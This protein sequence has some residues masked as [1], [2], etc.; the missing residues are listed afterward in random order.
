MAK[1]VVILQFAAANV[2]IAHGV[3]H[4]FANPQLFEA[5]DHDILANPQSVFAK[6]L[7]FVYLK[8]SNT[9][10]YDS[11][12][13][14]SRNGPSIAPRL[15]LL[16]PQETSPVIEFP[17]HTT[18]PRQAETVAGQCV[19]YTGNIFKRS[20]PVLCVL[21]LTFSWGYNGNS[22]GNITAKCFSMFRSI[23]GFCPNF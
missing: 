13:P 18:F 9:W 2:L 12:V 15:I 20:T 8:K 17:D 3:I 14:W 5:N 19:W 16:T 23:T 6:P 1:H 7:F 4:I 21:H 10:L 22:V 11:T